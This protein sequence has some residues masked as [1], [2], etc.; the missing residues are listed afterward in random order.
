MTVEIPILPNFAQNPAFPKNDPICEPERSETQYGSD[1]YKRSTDGEVPVSC[2]GDAIEQYS[3]KV[4]SYT[5]F[6]QKTL[7]R[8]MCV[9][10]LSELENP[11]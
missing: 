8:Y 9:L 2:T 11:E 7:R 5:F 3:T 1:L 4:A 10:R 6:R